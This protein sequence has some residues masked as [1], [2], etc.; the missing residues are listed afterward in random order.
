MRYFGKQI[1]LIFFELYFFRIYKSS[2]IFN[3]INTFYNIVE[4]SK[5]YVPC[6]ISQKLIC[7][8]LM[9]IVPI[10]I[11]LLGSACFIFFACGR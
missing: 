11:A 8:S 10:L 3:N 5:K 9:H 4:L 2:K 6:C 7:F 1:N